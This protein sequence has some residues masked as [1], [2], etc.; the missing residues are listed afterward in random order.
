MAIH[1]QD[2]GTHEAFLAIPSYDVDEK[3]AGRG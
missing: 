1:M 3:K 2:M